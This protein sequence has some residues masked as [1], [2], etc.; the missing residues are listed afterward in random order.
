MHNMIII[1][2][3]PSKV[4]LKVVKLIPMSCRQLMLLGHSS[5]SIN[6]LIAKFLKVSD[7]LG[8]LKS[9]Q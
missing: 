8:I 7:H 5:L 9:L 3:D 4:T 2:Y 6:L 1:Q